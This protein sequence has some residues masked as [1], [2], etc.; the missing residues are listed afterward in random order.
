MMQYLLR[1]EKE[2]RQLRKFRSKLS[3]QSLF[4]HTN[5]ICCAYIFIEQVNNAHTSMH[6]WTTHAVCIFLAT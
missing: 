5:E 1:H 4:L 2:Q 6:F 3:N